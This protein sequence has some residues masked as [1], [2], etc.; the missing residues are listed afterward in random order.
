MP[1]VPNVTGETIAQLRNGDER[2]FEAIYESYHRLIY[3]FAYSFLKNVELSK[4]VTQETFLSLW[5]NREKLDESLPLYPYLFTKAR[6]LT[7]DAFRRLAK[8][9]RLQA[10]WTAALGESNNDTEQ[11]M[12]HRELE[13]M[14]EAALQQMPKQQQLVFRMSR[15][16]GLSYEEIAEELQISKNTVKYHLVQSLKFLKGFFAKHG[17][18]YFFVLT[19]FI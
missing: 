14:T 5:V 12:F 13:V 7:I 17:I 3:H 18:L 9:Q 4:E 8:H 16:E 15:S 10:E 19:L 2:A 11:R 6:R 1:K